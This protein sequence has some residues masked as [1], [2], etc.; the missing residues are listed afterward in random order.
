MPT[1]VHELLHLVHRKN[2]FLASTSRPCSVPTKAPTHGQ[3]PCYAD[4]MTKPPRI[5]DDSPESILIIKHNHLHACIGASC[6]HISLLPPNQPVCRRPL[7]PS[8]PFPRQPLGYGLPYGCGPGFRSTRRSITG[9]RAWVGSSLAYEAANFPRLTP[10]QAP[11][12]L[13]LAPG[14]S[15]VRTPRWDLPRLLSLLSPRAPL[16]IPLARPHPPPG[17]ASGSPGTQLSVLSQRQP[18]QRLGG[19]LGSWLP[20]P[21]T[22]SRGIHHAPSCQLTVMNPGPRPT[23]KPCRVPHTCRCMPVADATP[24]RCRPMSIQRGSPPAPNQ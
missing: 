4:T 6:Y 17:R 5:S 15:I 11:S 10:S 14:F 13:T 2:Y 21:L 24:S 3:V 19:R 18:F 8:S 7:P 16:E 9:S 23:A 20:P 12:N 1:S 22:S